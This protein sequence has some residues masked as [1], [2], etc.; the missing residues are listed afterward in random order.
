MA[1]KNVCKILLQQVAKEH[2]HAPERN[3]VTAL[4]RLVFHRNLQ[5][6]GTFIAHQLAAFLLVSHSNLYRV[7]GPFGGVCMCQYG[8]I[9]RGKLVGKV[10]DVNTGQTEEVQVEIEILKPKRAGQ[11]VK[12][13]RG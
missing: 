10:L 12:K 5:D 3:L 9:R 8:G 7:A 2:S 4:G 13:R 6:D 11:A 1:T